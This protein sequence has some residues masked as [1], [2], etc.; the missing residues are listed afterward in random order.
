[1]IMLNNAASITAT[2]SCSHSLQSFPAGWGQTGMS[3][4]SVRAVTALLAIISGM[5]LGIY[6]LT[7]TE[8]VDSKASCRQHRRVTDAQ[9]DKAM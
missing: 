2:I 5:L 9:V 4:T 8:K 3:T 1:M 6:L 7:R